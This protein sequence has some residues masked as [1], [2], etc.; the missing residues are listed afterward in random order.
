MTRIAYGSVASQTQPGMLAGGDEV[1]AAD[2]ERAPDDEDA[3]L[4]EAVVLQPDRRR[5]VEDADEQP[6]EREGD[7]QRPADRG[8]DTA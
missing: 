2:H 3:R 8:Q 5:D 1:R 7:D 4:A 6:G